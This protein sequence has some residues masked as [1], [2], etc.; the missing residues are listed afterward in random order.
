ML[1]AVFPTWYWESIETYVDMPK[2][3][4]SPAT[5]TRTS[6]EDEA[7]DNDHDDDE[8]GGDDASRLLGFTLSALHSVSSQTK[9]VLNS[10]PM[11]NIRETVE[12]PQSAA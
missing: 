10:T 2:L 12:L 11:V 8:G 5:S 6:S 1:E 3:A 9:S 7:G 4:A